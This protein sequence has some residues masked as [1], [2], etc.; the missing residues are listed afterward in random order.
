[1]AGGKSFEDTHKTWIFLLPSVNEKFAIA[2]LSSKR[3]CCHYK[4]SS[5]RLFRIRSQAPNAFI[6]ARFDWPNHFRNAGLDGRRKA[7]VQGNV[8][9]GD[10]LDDMGIEPTASSLR[11]RQ[12]SR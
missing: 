10:L 7:K 2:E 5:V 9:S 4:T 1:M 12:H 8:V 6:I 11:T 3:L